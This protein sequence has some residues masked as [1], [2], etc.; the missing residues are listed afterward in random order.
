V[1]AGASETIA[2]LADSQFDPRQTVFLP[3]EARSLV[4]VTNASE[5]KISVRRFAAHAVELEV[6][7]AEPALVIVAQ[8]FYHNWHA[9]VGGQSTPLLRANH[10][11]QALEVPAGRS[12]VRL[13]YE[14]SPFHR[15]VAIST[16]AAAALIIAW[17]RGR[18]R[19]T[20]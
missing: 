18:R 19:P 5:V 1:F 20:G 2:A 6:E 13:A 8:S 10:A 9:Y 16:I 4:I 11:F 12:Q 17:L 15:G 14:D 3:P 7:A